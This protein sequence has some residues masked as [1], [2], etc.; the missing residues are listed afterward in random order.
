MGMVNLH[1]E[2]PERATPDT[3]LANT[4]RAVSE[5]MELRV[6]YRVELAALEPID[7]GGC[8]NL[9]VYWRPAP[10]EPQHPNGSS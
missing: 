10:S 9:C 3:R 5:L 7:R 8:M 2:W 4:I 6:G 1:T